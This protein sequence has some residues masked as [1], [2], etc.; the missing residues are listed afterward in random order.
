MNAF[1]SLDSDAW[2]GKAVFGLAPE[3][4]FSGSRLRQ[5]ELLEAVLEGTAGHPEKPG[6][7]RHIARLLLERLLEEILLEVLEGEPGLGNLDAHT[8]RRAAL[9]E[10]LRAYSGA[11]T[12][13]TIPTLIIGEPEVE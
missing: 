7:A 11:M 12:S 5:A 3:T 10:L 4:L 6:R 2:E 13:V 1:V 9:T 8:A